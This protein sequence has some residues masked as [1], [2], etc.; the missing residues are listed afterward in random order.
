[1]HWLLHWPYI[2]VTTNMYG[3]PIALCITILTLWYGNFVNQSPWAIRP[4]YSNV[5]ANK[6]AILWYCINQHHRW[7]SSWTMCHRS[8]IWS[9]EHP[10]SAC[11]HCGCHFWAGI[12]Q[13]GRFHWL[14]EV[15][16]LACWT[17]QR[18]SV[19]QCPFLKSWV[20]WRTLQQ[21]VRHLTKVKEQWTTNSVLSVETHV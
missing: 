4:T 15:V 12:A 18:R 8:I 20:C 11:L 5:R 3:Q 6:G 21:S 1:M 13:L 14:W 9:Q 7:K 16:A 17:L 10:T 2:N 19:E